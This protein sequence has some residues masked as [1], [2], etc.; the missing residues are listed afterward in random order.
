MC[1]TRH[2]ITLKKL[3]LSHYT[4]RKRLGGEDVKLLLIFDLG[5]RWDEWSALR[6]G[7]RTFDTHCTGGWVGP[8]AGLDT[9]E[10]SFASAEDRTSIV[11]SSSP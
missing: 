4:P 5:T 7:K 8:N 9:E 11:R 2:I 6:P 3:K 10:K 1:K